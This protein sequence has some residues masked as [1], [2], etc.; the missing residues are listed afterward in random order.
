MTF[1]LVPLLA[2][3]QF[4]DSA[5]DLRREIQAVRAREGAALA[6]LLEKLEKDGEKARAS[7]VRALMG[8]AESPNGA[9]RF[10]PLPEVV[11]GPDKGLPSLPTVPRH[12]EAAKARDRAATELLELAGR[13]A[14]V[15][16]P[17]IADECLRG[18]IDRRPDQAEARRLLGYVAHQGGWATPFA[19]EMLKR[20]KVDHPTYGWIDADWVPRLEQGLLPGRVVGGK[21]EQWLPAAD[22]DALRSDI[23]HGWE[24]TTAH[25]FIKTDVPLARAIAFGRQLEHFHQAF[26]SLMADVLGAEGALARRYSGKAPTAVKPHEV[27]Y[28]GDKAEYVNYLKR[29]H[30]QGVD[31]ELGR[32]DPARRRGEVGRS[33]F[34]RDDAGPVPVEA[35]LY[36]EASHQLLFESGPKSGHES[37]VGQYWVFEG[38]GTYFETLEALPDGALEIGGFV[39]PRLA[40]A[41]ERLVERGE[42]VPLDKF[43]A[44]SRTRFDGAGGGDVYLNYAQ[45]MALAVFLMQG[46][47]GRYRDEFLDYIADAYRGNYRR[48][49]PAKPLFERLGTTP[50]ALQT[51]FLDFLKKAPK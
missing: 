2:F 25:F 33:Y 43:V 24:I 41:R 39:G 46:D 17:S 47:Q 27:W 29:L 13:A 1:A 44:M 34:Y 22:A 20:K 26:H 5:A 3:T 36:H 45:A 11:P 6:T 15:G 38:L 42:C 14:K 30:G 50:D 19:I 32:F 12:P 31:L 21:P 10:L 51:R 23:L 16:R 8:P 35:T 37:N 28:F 18:V 49:G 40:L 4:P 7:E 48:G 9:W